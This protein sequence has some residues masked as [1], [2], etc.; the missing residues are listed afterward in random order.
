MKRIYLGDITIKNGIN[1]NTEDLISGIILTS[2]SYSIFLKEYHLSKNTTLKLQN[3][4]SEVNFIRNQK[5]KLWILTKLIKGYDFK[6]ILNLYF[7]KGHLFD[8]D[9]KFICT[10]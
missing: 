1:L 2:G 5:I 3:F 4:L 7:D 9:Y 6:K 10:S 8:K